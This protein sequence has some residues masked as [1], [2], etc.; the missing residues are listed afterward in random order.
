MRIF[1]L[2]GFVAGL[3]LIGGSVSVIRDLRDVSADQRALTGAAANGAGARAKARASGEAAAP[4]RVEIAAPAALSVAAGDRIDVL[5]TRATGPVATTI[6]ILSD[7]RVVDVAAG[8][9]LMV[10][11]EVTAAQSQRLSMARAAGLVTVTERSTADTT[12]KSRRG[13]IA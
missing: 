11:I 7:A 1:A 9:T 4:R 12:R 2:L 8:D 6:T 10:T 5:L 13:R 3:G